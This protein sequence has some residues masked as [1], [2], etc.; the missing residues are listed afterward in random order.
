MGQEKKL[1]FSA[2]LIYF[3]AIAAFV[4]V[5]VCASYGLFSF[6]GPYGSY[7]LGIFLQVGIIFLIPLFAYK[8]A[9][10]QK[11]SDPVRDFSFRKISLKAIVIS[12]VLGFVVFFINLYVSNFFNSAIRF[13]GYKPAQTSPA[14]IPATWWTFALDMLCTAVLPA[15]AEESL[16]RGMMLRGNFSLGMNRSILVSGFLFGLL[17]LNIE[18]FFYA[19]IIGIFLGYLC[20]SCSSIWPCIIV[21]F[22]NNATS[23]FL[24]FARQKGWGIGSILN[25]VT[26]NLFQNPMIGILLSFLILALLL[27]MAYELSKM[28]IKDSFN[29]NFLNKQKE[30]A[31]LA[32]RESFFEQ[33][34]EIKMR[35]QVEDEKIYETDKNVLYMNIDDFLKFVDENMDKILKK[36][37]EEE[38]KQNKRKVE[39]RTKIL[40]VA[41]FVLTSIITLMT[42]IWGLF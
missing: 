10:K 41:S 9:N 4:I 17:H 33:V 8:F 37:K 23:V 6:L 27:F 15:V 40:L 11:I 31:R 21:H 3:C 19:A 2:N 42:F 34:N 39:P 30:F 1:C 13:F 14:E 18:Q 25:S 29:Y 26:Q 7:F 38:D 20:V 22:M 12:V 24:S 32:V 35:Q 5:R 28:L 16:H 36:S